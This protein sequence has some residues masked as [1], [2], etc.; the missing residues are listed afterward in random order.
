M[1]GEGW[2]IELRRKEEAG[3]VSLSAG[4]L[5]WV[6]G[7]AATRTPGSS[8]EQAPALFLK[9][10]GERATA[11]VVGAGVWWGW[12]RWTRVGEVLPWRWEKDGAVGRAGGG[13]WWGVKGGAV[14]R[15][16]EPQRGSGCRETAWADFLA[17]WRRG[18]GL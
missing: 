9:G 5:A 18:L 7:V 10:E 16:P 2:L 1:D 6:A 17:G 12:G 15:Q 4:C 14:S 13:S 11:R 3:G 8:P